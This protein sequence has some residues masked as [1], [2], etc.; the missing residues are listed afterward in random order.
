M[1]DPRSSKSLLPRLFPVIYSRI[2]VFL[3]H[4]HFSLTRKQNNYVIGGGARS[5]A[6]LR[7]RDS[8]DNAD[9]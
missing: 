9:E 2:D 7:M 6:K 3:Q 5:P 4:A 1:V 8:F